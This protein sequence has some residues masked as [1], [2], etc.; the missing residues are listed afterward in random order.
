[1]TRTYKLYPKKETG[2]MLAIVHN[3]VCYHI[4]KF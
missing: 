3:R 1:M 4:E 2:F